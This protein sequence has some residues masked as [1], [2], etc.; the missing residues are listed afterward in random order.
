MNKTKATEALPVVQESVAIPAVLIQRALT[1]QPTGST[2]R[3]S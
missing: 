3:I 1:H 2:G